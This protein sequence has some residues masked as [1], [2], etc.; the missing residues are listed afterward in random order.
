M[1]TPRSQIKHGDRPQGEEDFL[2][3]EGLQEAHHPQGDPVQDWQGLPVRTREA[4]L[5]PQAAGL[6]WSDQA[7]VP[8]D[9]QDHQEDRAAS[10]VCRVQVQIA[11]RTQ[12]LQALR[13]CRQEEVSALCIHTI[14]GTIGRASYSWYRIIWLL[15][16]LK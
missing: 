10:G 3:S 16:Q 14:Q 11:L 1:G 8:Q 15:Q 4:P 13:S 12:A 2:R 9:G 7:C 6:R 5:R